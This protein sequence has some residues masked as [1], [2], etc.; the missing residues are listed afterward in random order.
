MV[1]EVSSD[2]ALKLYRSG[3][4]LYLKHV[5]EVVAVASDLARA[6]DVPRDRIRYTIF[7]NQPGATTRAHF[8]PVDTMTLQIKGSK[9]WRVAPNVFA[10]DPMVS[11]TTLDGTE[12]YA[13]L[14]LYAHD[15][16]PAAIPADREEYALKPGAM[17][18]VPRGFWHET[19]SN[20]ESM[21]LHLHLV[22]LPWVDVAMASL[23]S[24][25]MRDAAWR[26]SPIELW[27]RDQAATNARELESLLSS[28]VEAA[29]MLT[30]DWQH[31]C[32]SLHAPQSVP[33][34]SS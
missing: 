25:L 31:C 15:E 16:L 23:R 28:L 20:E 21:S 9:R 32:A 30:S 26:K 27:D 4:T 19:D 29:S 12:K 8:D 7:C 13:E 14:W 34:R 10:P 33:V 5:P 17:L 3:V 24:V 2:A 11:W 6:L 18:N 1:A 22:H